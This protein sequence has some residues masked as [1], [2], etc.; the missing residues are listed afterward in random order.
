M[1]KGN[2]FTGQPIYNQILSLISRR[3]IVSIARSLDADRYCKSF[4]T[5]EHL[6]TMLYA[7]LNR[8]DSLREVTTGLLAW[9][10]R[11]HHLGLKGHP[12]RSTISDANKRRSEQ[13]FE[14][15]Y[16]NLLARYQSL[17]PDS[18]KKSKKDNLYIF[19]STS[20]SL[21]QEILKASGLS[22]ANGKRKGGIKVH[23]LLH[24][25]SDTATMIRY[26][27]SA[28]SDVTYL[29]E[30][31]LP[32]GS[33]IIFDKGY[34][35]YRSY[36]RFSH[37]GVTFVTRHHDRSVYRTIKEKTVEPCQ[38]QQGVQ[39][40]ELI[41][42]G[43]TYKKKAV[44]VN[45]RLIKYKDPATKKQFKFLSNNT[46]L[47]P[48]T[49]AKYYKQRWQ[50]ETFFKRIKQNYPLKYFLGDNENAI[51]IQ[52][53]CALIA[54]LLLRV[55]KMG[56]KSRIS[57][58]NVVA[59]IRLHLM[60]YMDLNAFLKAPEKSLIIRAYQIHRTTTSPLLFAT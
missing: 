21:F 24:S 11:I 33:V 8:C 53:W 12:R 40:D 2:F 29:K 10:R 56:S 55:I 19:D 51:K 60:T 37:E 31:H 39:S 41:S 5:Y 35:D 58:S 38:Q 7:I 49:I 34:L 6:V 44:Q 47:A 52:I 25:A 20:I 32:K 57:F 59:L 48:G 23:T 1:S 43:Y 26:S 9:D 4:G 45:S 30:V 36:N 28:Q 15:I 50:I 3:D 13:V 27:P 14:K 54:D 17:L 46:R 18:R 22:Y 42:L 16:F